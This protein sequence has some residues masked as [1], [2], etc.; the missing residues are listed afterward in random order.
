MAVSIVARSVITPL[1]SLL[2]S[3]G[4]RQL[5]LR[6]LATLCGGIGAVSGLVAFA[7][8][9]SSVVATVAYCVLSIG[10]GFNQSGYTSNFLEVAGMAEAL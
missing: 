1:E 9:R 7:A 4:W 8:T 3:R 6:K 2:L 10:N 5:L